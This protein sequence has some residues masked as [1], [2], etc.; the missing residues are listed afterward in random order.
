[1]CSAVSSKPL[2]QWAQSG[3]SARPALK[4]KPR[5]DNAFRTSNQVSENSEWFKKLD[6][7]AQFQWKRISSDVPPCRSLR[8]S[9]AEP[10]TTSRCSSFRGRER[11]LDAGRLRRAKQ[12]LF[13]PSAYVPLGLTWGEEKSHLPFVS[14]PRPLSR[15]GPEKVGRLINESAF[16][17]LNYVTWPIRNIV[18]NWHSVRS[19]RKISNHSLFSSHKQSTFLLYIFSKVFI[20]FFY[21]SIV[22]LISLI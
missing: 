18:Q 6:P 12:T 3:R 8:V 22:N 9:E 13:R 19:S 1:M 16:V 5:R 2:L 21:T 17:A 7:G 11:S 4:F 14:T 20:I 15:I 10:T